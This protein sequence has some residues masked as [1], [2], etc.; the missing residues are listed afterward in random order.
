MDDIL[1]AVFN[2][3]GRDNDATLN[4]VMRICRQTS[5]KPN[6]DKCLFQCTS[7]PFFGEVI[8]QSGM[9][10]D[11]RKVQAVMT[12]PPPKREKAL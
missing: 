1:I 10:P 5:L 12:M 9:S 2:D 8:S 6:K 4:K 7:V 11:A 3:I